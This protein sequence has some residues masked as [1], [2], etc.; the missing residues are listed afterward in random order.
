LQI[1]DEFCIKIIDGIWF[2]GVYRS[3]FLDVGH[4]I[5]NPSNKGAEGLVRLLPDGEEVIP[6]IEMCPRML[7]EVCRKQGYSKS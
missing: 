4:A 2:L 7:L 1:A 3:K 5:L 6:G